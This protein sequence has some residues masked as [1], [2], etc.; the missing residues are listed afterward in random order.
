MSNYP[1]SSVSLRAALIGC[2]MIGS[3]FADDPRIKGIYTHAGAWRACPDVD[4]AAVCD[5]DPERARRCAERWNITRWYV[6]P[7]AMLQDVRPDIV[8][9]CTPDTTHSALLELVINSP[10]TRAVLIEK[11]LAL[12]LEEAR[13]AVNQAGQRGVRLGVNYSRRYSLGHQA[14][15]ERIRQGELGEL[16]SIGGHYGK[17]TLHNG[18]HWFDLARFLVGEI[19]QVR[20]FDRLHEACPDPTLDVWMEFS[21]GPLAYLHGL[22]AAAYS[23]FEMDILGSRGRVRIVD[24]GHGFETSMVGD[25]PYYTGY[26]TLLPHGREDGRLE[27]TL[28]HAAQDLVASLETGSTPLCS[29]EDALAALAVGLAAL[30]SAKLGGEPRRL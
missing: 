29:G 4:L 8:S 22:D 6:D 26:R 17:G 19:S 21:S 14:L 12:S 28:L 3:E 11:P 9:I 25:S 13:L 24:S 10:T 30:A 20:G 16:Q 7:A 15:R 5:T 1:G 2:G 23:L 18:T 27:D